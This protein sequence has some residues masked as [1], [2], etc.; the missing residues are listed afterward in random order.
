MKK[1][2]YT[3]ALV[4]ASNLAYAAPAEKAAAVAEK[5]AATADKAAAP[6]EKAAVTADKAAATAEKASVTAD[7]AAATAEKAATV[8]A[9]SEEVRKPTGDVDKFWTNLS[10][11]E[12]SAGEKKL[13]GVLGWNGRLWGAE[14]GAPA[15]ESTEW[16]KLSKEEQAAAKSL[17]YDEKSWNKE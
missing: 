1:L 12:L 10:W 17:G 6:A 13:W 14:S 5:A 11:D 2:A 15:S 7:K 16:K 4:V 8:E 3:L 9:K